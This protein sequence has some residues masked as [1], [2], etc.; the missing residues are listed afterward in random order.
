MNHKN[1][2]KELFKLIEGKGYIIECESEH[3]PISKDDVLKHQVDDATIYILDKDKID[4]GWIY[5]TFWNDWDE[6]ISDYTSDLD[7]IL[8]LD[9]F[10]KNYTYMTN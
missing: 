4:I 10:I 3:E 9:G 6:S 7:K 1:Y 8:N 5:W 2:A